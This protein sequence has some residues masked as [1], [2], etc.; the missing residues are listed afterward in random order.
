MIATIKRPGFET[1]GD[2]PPAFLEVV[3]KY[4]GKDLVE[5]VEEEGDRLIDITDTDWC[6]ERKAKR[7]PGHTLRMYRTMHKFTQGALAKIVGALP[8]HISEMEAG[9]RAISK[10]MAL[11]FAEIFEVSPDR[12]I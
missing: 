12:F 11:K 3:R 9:K 1:R 7:D 5:V 10:A 2:I 4:F 8:H 6:K